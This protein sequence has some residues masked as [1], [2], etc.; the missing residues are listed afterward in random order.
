MLSK[1]CADAINATLHRRRVTVHS[2][3]CS[4]SNTPTRR[5]I[6][7]SLGE[8]AVLRGAGVALFFEQDRFRLNGASPWGGR[9]AEA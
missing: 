3:F 5:T 4:T 8:M 1:E 6:A 7:A 9:A 2:S